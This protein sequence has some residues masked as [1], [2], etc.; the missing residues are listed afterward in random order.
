MVCVPVTGTVCLCLNCRLTDW[1]N[2]H[3]ASSEVV[4]LSALVRPR[5]KASIHGSYIISKLSV[6]I[7]L[8]LA[9]WRGC[10]RKLSHSEERDTFQE[11]GDRELLL[12][13]TTLKAWYL[14]PA[15]THTLA[16]YVKPA[17]RMKTLR[18]RPARVPP[19]CMAVL[20]ILIFLPHICLS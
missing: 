17:H 7:K 2:C 11:S 3:D 9:T 20:V 15:D 4:P 8:T 10:F 6:H 18:V 14:N 5:K 13:S 1:V 12:G 16:H 19:H